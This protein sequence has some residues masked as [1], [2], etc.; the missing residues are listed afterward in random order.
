VLLLSAADSSLVLGQVATITASLSRGGAA[1]PG[2]TVELVI[3][4]ANGTV[5]LTQNITTNAAG[6]ASTALDASS[7]LGIGDYTVTARAV[8][9]GGATT[10]TGV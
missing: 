4:L 3:A 7:L 2:Q 8:L 1:V 9:D 10:A 5:V 6:D